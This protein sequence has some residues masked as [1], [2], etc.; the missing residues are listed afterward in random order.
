MAIKTEYSQALRT[1]FIAILALLLG[2]S[3]IAKGAHDLWAATAVYLTLLILLA[4]FALAVPS[5]WRNGVRFPLLIP[6]LTL[7]A[8]LLISF[9]R[10]VNPSESFLGFMD[11]VAFVMMFYLGV[12]IF[13][14]ERDAKL[15]LTCLIPFLIWECLVVM[16][17][18]VELYYLIR[19]AN[20]FN[21]PHGTFMNGNFAVAY[22][23]LWLPALMEQVFSSRRSSWRMRGYWILG[24]GALWGVLIMMASTWSLVCI[25]TGAVIYVGKNRLRRLYDKNPVLF[26]TLFFLISAILL[27][28]VV[29]KFALLHGWGHRWVHRP[30]SS[31][32]DW[33]IAGLKMWKDHPWFGVGI[34]NFP[35]AYLSYKTGSGQNTLYAHSFFIQVLAEAGTVGFVAI[36]GFIAACFYQA[37]KNLFGPYRSLTVGVLMLLLFSS[38]H[39]SFENLSHLLALGLF[40]GILVSTTPDGFVWIPRTSTKIILVALALFVVP[41]LV[42]PFLASR[43]WVDGNS[44]IKE[45]KWD[46]AEKSFRSAL[47]L[48]DRSWEPYWGLAQV[49]LSRGDIPRAIRFGEQA[50]ERNRLSLRVKQALE[51]FK[52]KFQTGL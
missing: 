17:D 45:Q 16:G 40:L 29:R 19:Y 37:R 11:W 32:F 28:L 31:R 18:T 26:N 30:Q 20:V 2:F 15:L 35:S 46:L 24:A 9:W 41:Y 36:F 14:E 34:G 44:H 47:T 10:S 49:A 25:F 13:R 4:V 3:V 1:V 12:N 43:M 39:V 6:A 33:W 38:I 42:S 48:D 8:V 27:I 52:Q 22:S 7:L 51:N 21:E 5:R 50:L 23:L